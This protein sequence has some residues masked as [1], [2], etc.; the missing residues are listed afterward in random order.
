[1]KKCLLKIVML[2]LAVSGVI[3]SL[4]AAQQ[5][6]QRPDLRRLNISQ[7]NLARAKNVLLVTTGVAGGL[8]FS[9]KLYP[10]P[11]E[12]P[13][14]KDTSFFA[15]FVKY[16][17]FIEPTTKAYISIGSFCLWLMSYLITP[18]PKI[19]KV[20]MINNKLKGFLKSLPKIVEKTDTGKSFEI[21]QYKGGYVTYLLITMDK[22]PTEDVSLSEMYESWWKTY[23]NSVND[24]PEESK[25]SIKEGADSNLEKGE[26]F[27]DVLVDS[28]YQ[29]MADLPSIVS[30]LSEQQIAK[31]KCEFGWS[32]KLTVENVKIYPPLS[33]KEF[34]IDNN[35][36]P[37][38]VREDQLEDNL[39]E[40]Q[41]V[42]FTQKGKGFLVNDKIVRDKFVLGYSV[43]GIRLD[44]TP[45]FNTDYFDNKPTLKNRHSIIYPVQ[46]NGWWLSMKMIT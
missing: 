38:K 37:D 14:V 7:K 6:A 29:Y 23:I 5:P 24:L 28:I 26:K 2:F 43:E 40:L 11:A 9:N 16:A 30:Y 34:R 44:E 19:G 4:S 25:K 36:R 17:N 39:I 8:A 20:V 3:D 33:T 15:T 42:V 13:Y 46:K 22:K 27:P 41:D 10:C 35:G 45:L 18:N 1:M 12:N 31:V 21:R 32:T